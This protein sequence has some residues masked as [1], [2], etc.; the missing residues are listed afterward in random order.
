MDVNH[1]NSEALLRCLDVLDVFKVKI[2]VELKA[3][4]QVWD[5]F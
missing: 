4:S 2:T 1:T 3:H 5:K